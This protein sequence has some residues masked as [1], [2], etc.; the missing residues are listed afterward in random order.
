MMHSSS[1]TNELYR[2]GLWRFQVRVAFPYEQLRLTG[3][4]GPI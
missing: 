2:P 1:F 4:I 3:L